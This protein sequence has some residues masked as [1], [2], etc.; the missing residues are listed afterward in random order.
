MVPNALGVALW[1]DLVG[2]GAVP[3][4][5]GA[6][7]TLRLEAAMPL[8]GHELNET[9]DPIQAGLGWAVKLDKG[10]FIG[11]EALQEAAANAGKRPERVG[12]EL[13]GKR[14]AREG[15]A[16]LAA[17][18]APVGVVTSG[19]FA[20]W[21]EKSI[22]MGYVAPRYAAPGTRLLVDARGSTLPAA[23]VPLPFYKRKK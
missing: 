18:N 21:L 10:P 3:C 8:Y 23:V 6:R 7:D 14:A 20:P 22:A 19:S 1:E 2:R 4:G 5:L 9:I 12:L 11:R 16:I 17:E 13:E 15:C